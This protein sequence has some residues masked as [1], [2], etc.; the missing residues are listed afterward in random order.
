MAR[1]G[2]N[3]PDLGGVCHGTHSGEGPVLAILAM[4]ARRRRRSPLPYWCAARCAWLRVAP[5]LPSP[6]LRSAAC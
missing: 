3:L 2:V 1:F 5:L 6:P 4:L